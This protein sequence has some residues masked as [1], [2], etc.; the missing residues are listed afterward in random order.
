MSFPVET[1]HKL[2]GMSNIK[3]YSMTYSTKEQKT[4]KQI[5]MCVLERLKD[6]KTQSLPFVIYS[7]DQIS[8]NVGHIDKCKQRYPIIET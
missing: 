3:T 1:N 7:K 8:T 4:R 5:K 6:S 2:F